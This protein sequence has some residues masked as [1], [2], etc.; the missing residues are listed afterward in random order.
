MRR[1]LAVQLA[2]GVGRAAELPLVEPQLFGRTP[3]RSR[4]EHAVVRHDTLE[5]V[6][7]A[8]NPVSHVSA[9][10]GTER[11]FAGFINKP[12]MLFHVVEAL[13]QVLKRSAAPVAID[14]VNELLAIAGRAVEVDHD[15]INGDWGGADRKSTR[16]NSSHGY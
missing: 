13:H 8:E 5:A 6:G 15:A 2:V 11:A 7:V 3:G 14:R 10:A 1:P 9:V 4:V 16:L 12:I